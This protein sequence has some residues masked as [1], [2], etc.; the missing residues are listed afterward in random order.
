MASPGQDLEKNSQNSRKLGF[1][2][3]PYE[4]IQR[5]I[6]GWFSVTNLLIKCA[7]YS[8]LYSTWLQEKERALQNRQLLGF[9]GV[10]SNSAVPQA[11]NA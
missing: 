9:C 8:G 7:I 6:W 10:P 4:Q 3:F 2:E 5:E 11:G 1:C